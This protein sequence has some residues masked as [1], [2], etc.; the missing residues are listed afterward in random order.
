METKVCRICKRELPASLKY[1]YKNGRGLCSI[2]KEC[3]SAYHKE[4]Y[5]AHKEEIREIHKR[6]R[7]NSKEHIRDQ[8]REYYRAHPEVARKWHHKRN[9]KKM[10]LPRS[11]TREEWSETREYFGNVCAYCGEPLKLTQDHFIPISAGGGYV[12]GNIIPACFSCNSSKNDTPFADWYREK[13]FYSPERE[14][15]ILAFTGGNA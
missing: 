7:D 5:K 14:Q 2:C 1:F 10:R 8:H 6:W 9:A 4:Y 11:F 12:M 13:D 3:S 15:R